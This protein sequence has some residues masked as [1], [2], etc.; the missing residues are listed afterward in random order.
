MDLSNIEDVPLQ[1]LREVFQEKLDVVV[2]EISRRAGQPVQLTVVT[3]PTVTHAAVL[4]VADGLRRQ[5]CDF[6]LLQQEV[7][8]ECTW[9]QITFEQLTAQVRGPDGTG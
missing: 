3:G 8:S 2:A 9:R 1:V 6:R 5:G 7:G 4:Y